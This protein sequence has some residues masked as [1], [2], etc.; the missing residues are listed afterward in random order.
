MADIAELKKK[1]NEL[2]CRKWDDEAIKARVK[3][4][5]ENDIPRKKL[6]PAYMKAHKEEI[7]DR[8]QLRAEEYNYIFKNCAQ[9]TALALL[10]EFGLGSMEIIKAL[11]PFPGVASTGEICGGITGSL[12]AFGLFFG[13][14]D[15]F[16]FEAMNKA[17][18]QG[19]KFMAYFEDAIGSFYCA[20][21]IE[22]VIIG[23]KLNPGESEASMMAFAGAKGFEKC[24]L[25]PG[26]GV[27]LA[28]G[29]MIDSMK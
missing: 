6:D 15:R 7:L 4:L 9:G 10:E 2:A 18:S 17:I 19:Q 11:T 1:A 26:T 12:I 20:D 29:F 16:D 25:P 3:K 24:G 14:D 13:S 21:I 22:T 28:A 27:R 5:M 8:V 23:R